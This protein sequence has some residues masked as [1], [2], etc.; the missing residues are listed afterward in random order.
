VAINGTTSVIKSQGQLQLS[1]CIAPLAALR[2]GDSSDSILVLSLF[3]RAL[4]TLSL[5]H[6]H[7]HA[8][9]FR[10]AFFV[11]TD[12]ESRVVTKD[13]NARK[14]SIYRVSLVRPFRVARWR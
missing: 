6:L 3:I 14:K 2:A 8:K 4:P 10:V 1:D 13:L 11:K 7:Q 5:E 9:N 12:S